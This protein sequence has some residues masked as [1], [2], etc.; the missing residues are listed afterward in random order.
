MRTIP[1][2]RGLYGLYVAKLARWTET[3]GSLLRPGLTVEREK[4]R[5]KPDR[6]V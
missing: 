6:D 2:F 3:I 4:G 5:G 1:T